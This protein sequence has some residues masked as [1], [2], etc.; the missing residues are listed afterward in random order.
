MNTFIF[1]TGTRVEIDGRRFRIVRIFADGR[2]QLESEI[3]GV[4]TYSTLDQLHRDYAER[5][6]RIYQEE[7]HDG[8]A[9]QQLGRSLSTFPEPVQK[10]AIRRKRYLDFFSEFGKF[11]ST[12]VLLKPLI[13]ECARLINDTK[14]PSAI[15]AYR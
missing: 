14:L 12:P 9:A 7:P 1:K 4:L 11:I 15:T 5:R 2:V 13:D 6:L 3:D 8:E 10:E